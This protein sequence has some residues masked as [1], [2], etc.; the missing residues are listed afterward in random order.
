MTVHF[1]RVYAERPANTSLN[2]VR[3]AV[4]WWAD[5]HERLFQDEGELEA[6]LGGGDS[7]TPIPEHIRA[8]YYFTL[9]A[10]KRDLLDEAEDGLQSVVGWYVLEYY[11]SDHD[12]P[13]EDRQGCTLN[14][15]RPWGPVPGW[16]Q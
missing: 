15:R 10:S 4:A 11:G 16:F 12:L 2:A 3:Q 8:D 14:E 9:A 5:K 6:T 7:D 1:V 13:P